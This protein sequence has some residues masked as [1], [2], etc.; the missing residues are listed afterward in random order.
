M[1]CVR[2]GSY[3]FYLPPWPDHLCTS[4]VDPKRRGGGTVVCPADAR[5]GSRIWY[6]R[7]CSRQV[8]CAPPTVGRSRDRYPVHGTSNNNRVGGSLS[9]RRIPNMM[10]TSCSS[11]GSWVCGWLLRLVQNPSVQFPCLKPL[12][13]V[14]RSVPART[15]EL[16][17][18]TTA[19]AVMIEL[20]YSSIIS[21]DTRPGLS[22]MCRR[23]PGSSKG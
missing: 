3:G 9:A 18:T 1:L 5:F 15:E 11:D 17:S 7:I 2:A 14:Y 20:Y 6:V 16:Y 19:V 23:W 8:K 22:P 4:R 21:C 12:R 13:V 10:C